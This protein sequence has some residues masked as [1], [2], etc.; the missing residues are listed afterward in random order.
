MNQTNNLLHASR[1]TVLSSLAATLAAGW[2]LTGCSTAA[3]TQGITRRPNL[4][5]I[6]ADDLGYSDIG[7]YGGEIETPNLDAL[8]AQGRLLPRLIVAPVCSPTRV[9]LMS[10]ADHHLVGVGAIQAMQ[11]LEPS[12]FSVPGHEG[13]LNEHSLS[14]AQLLRDAGYHTYI[15]GKWHLAM[16]PEQGPAHHGFE[17]SFCLMG[18]SGPHWAPVAGKPIGPDLNAVFLEDGKRVPAPD[19]FYSSKDFSDRMIDFIDAG[20]ADGKPFF[21]YL[22]YTAPHWPIA[23]PDADIRHYKGRYDAGYT[24]IREAR[25]ARQRELGLFPKDA[26]AAQAQPESKIFPAWDALS[27]EERRYEARRMEVYAAMVHNMDRNIGKVLQHLRD[28]GEYDNTMVLF[29]SDNGACAMP[30][31]TIKPTN[32][33]NSFTNLGRPGSYMDYGSRW[34]EVSSAPLRYFKWQTTEGGVRVP[35]IVRMPGQTRGLP[36]VQETLHVTDILP[37]LLA[38]S[39]TPLPG[40]Q[41][42]GRQVHPPTGV[43]WLP[44]LKSATP[45]ALAP[46]RILCEEHVGVRSARQ[47]RWKL[48]TFMTQPLQQDKWA[49]FDLETD[50]GETRDLS[51]VHPDIAK[52]LRTAWEEYSRTSG[53]SP[54]TAGLVEKDPKIRGYAPYAQ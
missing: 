32:V 42:K 14:V 51:E 1:R 33:D 38:L 34:A 15:S 23:A 53:V 9:S 4:L 47:G 40:S 21:G 17:R 8:A 49:L 3:N 22:A 7:A 31:N 46:D 16:K 52:R 2:S 48:L 12:L 25:I 11:N 30:V 43:S 36:P 18:G 29:F 20:R 13:Y 26:H 19:D 10:G 6:L 54:R 37:T 28:I 5:V 27:P 39:Q 24:A 35:G 45:V 41:Y 50:P 44:A